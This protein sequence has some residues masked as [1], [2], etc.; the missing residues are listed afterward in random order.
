MKK[1]PT[2]EEMFFAYLE[3]KLK[4]ENRELTEDMKKEVRDNMSFIFESMIDFAKIHTKTAIS[5]ITEH[6]KDSCDGEDL[7]NTDL[8]EK[9][10][11]ECYSLKVIK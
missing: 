1:M 4:K 10:I 3:E 9:S 6:V 5:K 7:S 8:N 2:A 11:K